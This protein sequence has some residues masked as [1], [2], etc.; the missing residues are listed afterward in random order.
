MQP[1]H[2]AEANRLSAVG[3]TV[4]VSSGANVA[5]LSAFPAGRLAWTLAT[6]SHNNTTMKIIGS[7]VEEQ[8]ITFA[9][10]L[11]KDWAT[12]TQVESDKAREA[13]Q[14]YF[15][16]MPLILASQDSKGL[17][18]YQG[19]KDIVGFLANIDPSRIPW[20]DYEATN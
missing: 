10:V 4:E 16:G 18:S 1:N 7:I 8:G 19:R 3:S 17:F 11:V 14:L 20:K 5:F 12:Q 15:P 13:F 6:T 2:G 9:I